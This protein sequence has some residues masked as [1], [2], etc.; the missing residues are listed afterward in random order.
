MKRVLESL[1]G[2]EVEDDE[3]DGRE[4]ESDDNGEC[5]VDDCDGVL[6]DVF[7]IDEYLRRNEPPPDVVERMRIARD[8]R[9]GD[10]S[11]PAGLMRP[12]SEQDAQ[13]AFEVML[14]G[15]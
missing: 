12:T 10:I 14:N 11:P 3:G 1:V 13:E 8:W 9:L 7:D 15:R 4:D 2:V 6:I 5:P